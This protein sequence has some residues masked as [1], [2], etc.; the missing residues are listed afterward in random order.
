MI[1][2][3]ALEELETQANPARAE[4]MRAYHKAD[5]RYLGLTNPQIAELTQ[6]WREALD[7]EGRVA[8][9]DGLW[10]S[11]I[12]EARV[13]A[14][15]LLTQARLRPDDQAAWALIAS[16]TPDFDSWA[17]ADHASM[18]A[19]KRLAA[20]PSRLDE[21]ESCVASDHL[22]TR[23]AVLVST[24]PWTKQNNP[25]PEELDARDRILGWA[26]TMVPDHRQ[27]I[28]KAIGAWLRDLSKHDPERT[29]AFIAAHGEAMKPVAVKE[30]LRLLKKSEGTG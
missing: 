10:Q 13:A 2:E 14:A 17:I 4:E 24:L 1:I 20:E 26:A 5:R 7:V 6:A 8:L 9:A 29:R 11:D 3:T 19:Q 28:Q 21:L 18:A 30:A 15:K 25:K 23:R 22:W 16:W 27:F 12:F